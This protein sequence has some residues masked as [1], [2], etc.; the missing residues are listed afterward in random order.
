MH[1][2]SL[3]GISY[4]QGCVCGITS[5]AHIVT[6]AELLDDYRISKNPT[7]VS[8]GSAGNTLNSVGW[9]TLVTRNHLPGGTTALMKFTNLLHVPGFGVNLLSVKHIT[10]Y[11]HGCEV[12]FKSG[13]RLFDSNGE[14]KG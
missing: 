2:S 4:Q 7:T 6:S 13:A 14:L 8:W 11:G 3:K 1:A 10:S 5:T 9:G 12:S